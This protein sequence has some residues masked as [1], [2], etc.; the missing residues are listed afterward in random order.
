[1]TRPAIINDIDFAE[2]YRNHIQLASRESKTAQD[3]DQKAEK[4]LQNPNDFRDGFR[5]DYVNAFLAKMD[6]RPNDSVLDVGCGGGAIGL[7]LASAVKQVYALDFSEKMLDVV[8]TRAQQLAID[9]VTPMLKS[10]Y[11]DWQDVPECDICVSSRSSMVNDLADA[12]HKLNSK[13]KRAVYMTMTVEKDF[14]AIDILRSIRRDSIGFPSYIYALNLLHQQGYQVK[15]DFIQSC[16]GMTQVPADEWNEEAFIRSV[17]WSIGQ[18]NEQEIAKLKRYFA[19]QHP[20]SSYLPQ[21]QWA[22]LSWQKR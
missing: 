17:A 22:F 3:W 14:I 6:L 10:W 4:M 15:V 8:K 7:S 13:A 5:D 20:R 12:L 16:Y 2:L 11:D 18:L 21:R 19:E 1:M 9:N